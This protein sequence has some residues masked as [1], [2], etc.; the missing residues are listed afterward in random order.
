MKIP[1]FFKSK[2]TQTQ[3]VDERSKI[4][5]DDRMEHP[6]VGLTPAKLHALLTDAED[7]SL[8]QQSELFE[9]IEERDAHIYSELDKRKRALTSLPW[10]VKPPRDAT[11][12]ELM[13]TEAVEALLEG[14]SDFEDVLFDG[15][16]A[17]GKGFSS[18]EMRWVRDGSIWTIDSFEQIPQARFSSKKNQILLGTSSNPEPLWEHGWFTH[19]HKAKSGYVARG[20]LHR[21]LVWP[22]IF[23]AYSVRDLAEFLESYGLPVR[24]G[25]YP[26]G[27]TEREKSTLLQAVMQI[28]HRAA[29]IIPKG[30][31]I[32]FKE[33]AKGSS[34]PY[35]AM[36]NWCEKSASKAI[37][38]GTLM[39]QADGKTSTNALG[40]VHENTFETLVC[41]DARQLASSVRSQIIRSFC[42]I[43]YPG[44]DAR[45]LPIFEF[46]TSEPEDIVA[47][48]EA[49]P[50]LAEIGMTFKSDWVYDKLKIPK[51]ENGDEVIGTQ[52]TRDKTTDT[53]PDPAAAPLTAALNSNAAQSVISARGEQLA[54]A[55][56]TLDNVLASTEQTERIDAVADSMRADLTAAL[57]T[58]TS[59]E[60]AL[61]VIAN[62]LP[63]APLSALSSALEQSLTAGSLW[64]A[65]HSQ[66]QDAGS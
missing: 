60:E 8:K 28:G 9:D 12:A 20:G 46:D 51:P 30:M 13:A 14:L 2:T 39:S 66:T 10:Q 50:K 24:L 33:A 3:S 31:E 26:G 34:D 55:Q 36:I 27:A 16:D 41:S 53:K 21:I 52:P 65:L 62:Q 19:V 47:Y 43:N 5:L 40:Q 1:S 63:N 7:G 61:E 17:L 54:R 58:A 59:F 48:S 45:R 32:D 57:A 49:L 11:R 37:V 56:L 22:F 6:A 23:K 29:G 18:Q 64:G 38:G 25:T 4:A 15:M 35:Q 42:A 44:I